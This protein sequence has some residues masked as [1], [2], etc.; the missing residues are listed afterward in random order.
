MF[1]AIAG[2]VYDLFAVTA[3][4]NCLSNDVMLTPGALFARMWAHR[5][6]V[7]LSVVPKT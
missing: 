1:I 6:D 5:M 3:A 7:V 2:S 4:Y